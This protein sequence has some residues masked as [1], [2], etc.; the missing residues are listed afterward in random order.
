M[1][2]DDLR[3][4]VAVAE[5]ES[6]REAGKILKISHTTVARRI[7]ALEHQINAR[8]FE[9]RAGGLQLSE[10]GSELLEIARETDMRLH[11]FQSKVLGRKSEL[12]GE[13]ILTVSHAHVLPG[14]T[15]VLAEFIE[16]HPNLNLRIVASADYSNLW[17]R[18]ADVAIRFSN[19]PP[20]HLIGRKLSNLHQ[21]VYGQREYVEM[22]RP[23]AKDSTAEWI[24]WG[25]PL[26]RPWWIEES[27]FPHLGVAAHCDDIVFQTEALR[28]GVGICLFPCIIG[29]A[30]ADMVRLSEPEP[31]RDIWV[32]FHP[33]AKNSPR[34]NVLKSALIDYLESIKD[35]LEGIT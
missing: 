7:E 34:I 1:K 9:R 10:S 13:L 32:L 16:R 18:E 30:M 29:D 24:A 2:W 23:E 4:F 27:R 19:D 25:E 15:K 20:E 33:H 21:A 6:M 14:L 11:D 26:V 12:E 35:K 5:S 3:V 17:K 28:E 22:N 31:S 8:L